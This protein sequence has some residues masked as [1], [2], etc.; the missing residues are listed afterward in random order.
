MKERGS[1]VKCI[2]YV[3]GKENIHVTQPQGP[4]FRACS[5]FLI[6]ACAISAPLITTVHGLYRKTSEVSPETQQLESLTNVRLVTSAEHVKITWNDIWSIL[7]KSFLPR[8][9]WIQ[10]TYYVRR[11]LCLCSC[12]LYIWVPSLFSVQVDVIK[13]GGDEEDQLKEEEGKE[14][15]FKGGNSVGECDLQ[16]LSFGGGDDHHEDEEEQ[17]RGARPSAGV[18]CLS[19]MRSRRLHQHQ[20]Q[21]RDEVLRPLRIKKHFFISCAKAR[22][23]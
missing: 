14:E 16:G 17:M 12:L 23:R 20:Q 7:R 3:R 6:I 11:F 18:G 13:E 10:V 4:C 9:S 15:S 19:W 1:S 8:S 2:I 21:Q 5:S 22:R